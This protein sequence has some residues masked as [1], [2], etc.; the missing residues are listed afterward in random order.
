[1]LLLLRMVYTIPQV[2][3]MKQNKL[4]I[5]NSL[6][7]AHMPELAAV[8][9]GSGSRPLAVQL[10]MLPG[11]AADVSPEV[12]PTRIMELRQGVSTCS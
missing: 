5:P 7:H 1:L 12:L 6:V 3:N 10:V 8:E 11:D 9:A 2:Q 4:C